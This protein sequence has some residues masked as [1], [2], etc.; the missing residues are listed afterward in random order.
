MKNTVYSIVGALVAVASLGAQET[1]PI[2]FQVGVGFTQGVGRT[3]TY[4]DA[5]W[6]ATAGLGFNFGPYVG[7]LL[8]LGVNT[9]GINSTTLGGIGVPGGSV[10]IF[11]ATVDPV[12]HLMP[13]SHTDVYLTGG[14]GE[15]RYAQDF[16]QPNSTTIVYGPA[17]YF[18]FN[19][20]SN[21]L[22]Y[23]SSVNKPGFDVGIGF[24]V[25]TKW[26]G[27]LFAEAKY[28]KIFLNNYYHADY[29]PVTFGYRW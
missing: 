19:T 12:L 5:G 28:N 16:V 9:M 29:L 20:Y 25:G 14:G 21:R 26:H 24:A 22:L 18:G 23:S 4:T 11:S 6:N 7:A 1:S 15:Y 10:T 17:P 8:D 13:H 27:K 3:G 2:A